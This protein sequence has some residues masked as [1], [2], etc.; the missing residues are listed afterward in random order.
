[1]TLAISELKNWIIDWEGISTQKGPEFS[2]SLLSRKQIL[3]IYDK[4]WGSVEKKI[5][6]FYRLETTMS[7]LRTT[8]QNRMYYLK[9]QYRIGSYQK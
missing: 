1:M 8:P 5:E 2:K 7:H 9:V 4:G 6:H 3:A